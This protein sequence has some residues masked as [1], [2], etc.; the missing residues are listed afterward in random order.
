MFALLEINIRIITLQGEDIVK[1]KALRF[2]TIL[3][4]IGSPR[5]GLENK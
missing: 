5:V 3:E 2:I 1:K 4:I